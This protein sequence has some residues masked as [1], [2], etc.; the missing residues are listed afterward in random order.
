MRSFLGSIFYPVRVKNRPIGQSAEGFGVSQ[1]GSIFAFYR[2][3]P[4][5]E[6][7]PAGEIVL[8]CPFYRCG[9]WRSGK[10]SYWLK[11]IHLISGG[12]RDLNPELPAHRT[13]SASPHLLTVV[14]AGLC[15]QLLSSCP[16][17]QPQVRRCLL[18]EWHWRKK[19][20]ETHFL[21]Y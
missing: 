19:E 17:W 12:G 16:T 7:S 2:Q 6:N 4:N 9:N 10:V 1:W 3:D 14:P 11:V 15:G 20:E 21:S 13:A 18:R 5:S 8:L